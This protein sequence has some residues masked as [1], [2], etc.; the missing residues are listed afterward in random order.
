M[1]RNRG[2]MFVLLSLA[3]LLAFSPNIL[4]PWLHEVS[5]HVM[6]ALLPFPTTLSWNWRFSGA[7][8]AV[9]LSGFRSVCLLFGAYSPGRRKEQNIVD[10]VGLY[11]FLFWQSDGLSH[12]FLFNCYSLIKT[13]DPMSTEKMQFLFC[14]KS[15]P[16][17]WL[18]RNLNSK[19]LQSFNYG[20]K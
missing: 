10:Y 6:S 16:L 1:W 5:H 15:N 14:C 17:G 2:V 19:I 20:S 3:A 4:S 13:E 11:F 12:Y 9:M 18:S 8:E 7:P